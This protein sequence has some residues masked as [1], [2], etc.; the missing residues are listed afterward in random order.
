MN[1]IL[2]ATFAESDEQLRDIVV[3]MESLREFGCSQRFA[4]L[5]VYL[6]EDYTTTDNQLA[7][8]LL[9]LGAEI[10]SSSTPKTETELYFVGKVY[11]AGKAEADALNQASILVWLDSDTLFLDEPT[12]LLLAAGVDLAYRPV[13]HNRSGSLYSEPPDPFWAR[14]YQKLSLSD[15]QLFPMV[16][17]A[18]HQEI[19]AYFNSGLLAVRPEFGIFRKWGDDFTVL[20]T[21]SVLADMCAKDV[22]HKIFLHQTALVG[23]ALNTLK[24]DQMVELDHRYNYPMLFK[25]MYGGLEEFDSIDDVVT[26]RYESY[27]RDSKLDW[28]KKLKGPAEKIAWIKSRLGGR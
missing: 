28:D 4:P 14:I 19:R 3:M 23:S 20:H 7:K 21:D 24:P 17:P 12:E 25:E 8:Q 9:S 5:W 6:S 27:F 13:M 16:T 10:R 22:T 11:A 26:L 2:F 1:P 15:N 18:D